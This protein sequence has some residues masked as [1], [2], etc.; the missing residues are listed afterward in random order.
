MVP[1]GLNGPSVTE[2]L[3]LPF[4]CCILKVGS[5]LNPQQGIERGIAPRQALGPGCLRAGF[6]T[7]AIATG[8]GIPSCCAEL[9]TFFVSLL[10]SE[11]FLACLQL[12]FLGG[13]SSR[14]REMVFG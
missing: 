6:G 2:M 7:R 3:H 1:V 4:S 12:L 8:V 14:Q 9:Q 13:G 11:G 10:L 5:I